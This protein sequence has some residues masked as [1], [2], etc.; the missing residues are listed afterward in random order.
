M[1]SVGGIFSPSTDGLHARA[2]Q[3]QG[4]GRAMGNRW[5]ATCVASRWASS[6][7]QKDCWQQRTPGMSFWDA[8]YMI[9]D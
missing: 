9:Y 2:K 3:P 1:S 5:L 6:Q 7:D 4:Q 8:K